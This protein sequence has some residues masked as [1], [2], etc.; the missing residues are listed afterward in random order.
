VDIIREK[1][2]RYS[3]TLAENLPFHLR[4][5][6]R[7]ACATDMTRLLDRFSTEDRWVAGSMA[8]TM[9]GIITGALRGEPRAFGTTA[10][11]VIGLLL[12]GWRVTRSL[13]LGWL[14]VAGLIAGVL[15]LW[16]DWLHVVYFQS[17]VYTDYFGFRVLA[18]P[19]YMP[20]GWWLTVVQFGY[21]GLRV[22]ENRSFWFAVVLVTGAGLL[23]PPWYEELA[24]RAGAWYYR[25]GQLM[26]GHTPVW[27]IFT[28]GGCSFAIATL[29]LVFYRPRAWGRAALAGLF[30]AA[31]LMFSSVFWY[32]ILGRS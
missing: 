1:G 31:S 2:Q 21:L 20:V 6:S 8:V 9:G 12:I 5:C 17:L 30:T 13:R 26:V 10:F 25:P 23:L 29:A 32:S 18:S 15:E 14:L 27:I 24:F 11:G 3:G 22:A 4:R 16:A 28:Y 19:S 7:R